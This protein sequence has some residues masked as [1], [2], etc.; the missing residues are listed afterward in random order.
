MK[1]STVL[2][3]LALAALSSSAMA[4]VITYTNRAT[5]EAAVFGETT[6]TFDGCSIPSGFTVSN[7]CGSGNTFST[8]AATGL[9]IQNN[10][11]YP[12]NYLT[13]Q[14]NTKNVTV[15][16]D[17]GTPASA[18][19]FDASALGGDVPY[20]ITLSSGETF[21]F[22]SGNSNIPV[23]YQFGGVTANHSFSSFDINEVGAVGMVVD[24]LS[25]ASAVPLPSVAWLLLWGLGFLG[26]RM[27]NRAA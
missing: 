7:L 1:L 14:D 15:H 19:G 10:F 17:L 26:V 23:S 9:I 20:T 3:G 5:W 24:N 16:V 22:T 11:G 2:S 25:L 27:R 8:T 18:V 12:S 6:T 21:T 13:A 4:S